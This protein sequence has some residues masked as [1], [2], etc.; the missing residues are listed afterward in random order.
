[1]LEG[2]FINCSIFC[3][4]KKNPVYWVSPRG[5]LLNIQTLELFYI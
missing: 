1:M 3:E 5:N 2:L 4:G